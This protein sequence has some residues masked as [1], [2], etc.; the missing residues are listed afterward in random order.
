M[1]ISLQAF[2]FKGIIRALSNWRLNN[3]SPGV[4]RSIAGQVHGCATALDFP[5]FPSDESNSKIQYLWL[6][7][8]MFQDLWKSNLTENGDSRRPSWCLFSCWGQLLSILMRCVAFAAIGV[9]PRVVAAWEDALTPTSCGWL[10]AGWH[11]FAQTFNG[12]GYSPILGL[13]PHDCYDRW[14]LRLA[15]FDIQSS[16]IPQCPVVYVFYKFYSAD[17]EE[18]W[19]QL[20]RFFESRCRVLSN[21]PSFWSWYMYLP[22]S[23]PYLNSVDVSGVEKLP[24]LGCAWRPIKAQIHHAHTCCYTRFSCQRR[25][26]SLLGLAIL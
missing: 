2:R 24:Q 25:F 20:I 13:V 10:S 8:F 7:H 14:R 16:V 9:A 4:R 1:S 3:C 19:E 21:L 5:Q 23:Q 22:L 17:P 15:L 18:F 11:V 26:T 6:H 12:K